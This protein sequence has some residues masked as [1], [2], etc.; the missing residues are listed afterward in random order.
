TSNQPSQRVPVSATESMRLTQAAAIPS[1]L[2]VPPDSRTEESVGRRYAATFGA[3]CTQLVSSLITAGIVP[4][5]LGPASYGNYSFLLTMSGMLRGFTEPS[6]QQAFFTF[7]AQHDESG[8]LTRM[9]GTW[10]L[11]QL[12]LLLALIAAIAAMG[13]TDWVWPGQ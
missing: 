11:A 10:V 9:Y 2:G 4:R 6:V 12:V 8:P 5:H 13:W 1:E 7:S 3:Q